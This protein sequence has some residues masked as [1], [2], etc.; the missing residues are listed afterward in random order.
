VEGR[1]REKSGKGSRENKTCKSKTMTGAARVCGCG[2]HPRGT[3]PAAP[4]AVPAVTPQVC[5]P[6]ATSARP[7][8]PS[9]AA[10][11]CPAPAGT[12]VPLAAR[13]DAAGARRRHRPLSCERRDPRPTRGLRGAA[14]RKRA[15]LLLEGSSADPAARALPR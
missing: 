11:L 13:G 4:S 3:V 15:V 2:G 8:T 12:A 9:N 7:R 6:S 1:G 10:G 14:A 5:V